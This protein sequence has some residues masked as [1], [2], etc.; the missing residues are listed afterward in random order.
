MLAVGNAAS[1]LLYRNHA[2]LLL[3]LMCVANGK[4]FGLR[5]ESTS[6]KLCEEALSTSQ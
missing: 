1:K 4:Q 5:T 6:H 3:G 2:G